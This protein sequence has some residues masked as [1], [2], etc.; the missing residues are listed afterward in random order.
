MGKRNG[1][2]VLASPLAVSVLVAGLAASPA[3]AGPRAGPGGWQ[4]YTETP[5]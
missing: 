3:Y 2:A 5:R 1:L 4:S